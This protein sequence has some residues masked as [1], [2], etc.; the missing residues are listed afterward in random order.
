[1]KETVYNLYLFIDAQ[2]RVMYL[3]HILYEIE[4]TDYEEEPFEAQGPE[5]GGLAVE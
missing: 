4:G 5:P 1:M 3:G 2:G